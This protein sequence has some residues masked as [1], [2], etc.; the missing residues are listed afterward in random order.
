MTSA[1]TAGLAPV[2]S[3]APG[4]ALRDQ[5]NQ[6]VGLDALR[7]DRRVVLVFFPLAFTGNCE[8]ELGMIRDR[9]PEFDNDSHVTVAISVGPPPTHKVWSVAQA[10]LF[11]ILSDFWPHGDVARS[12]GVFDE[13]RGYSLRGTFVVDRDGTILFAHASEPGAPRDDSVWDNAL[14]IAAG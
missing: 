2:G 3:L 14:R 7:S 11:P 4:F 5:N 9:L 8:G 6:L 12:Y 10:F 1:S 13:E